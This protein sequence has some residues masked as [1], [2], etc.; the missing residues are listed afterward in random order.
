MKRVSENDPMN[1]RT[2]KVQFGVEAGIERLVFEFESMI[3]RLSV[4]FGR[5]GETY[6]AVCIWTVEYLL[7]SSALN[8]FRSFKFLASRLSDG[9]TRQ[10]CDRAS[11]LRSCLHCGR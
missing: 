5:N 7:I 8:S 3:E 2:R 6:V 10:S 4:G 9:V 1:V 11:R